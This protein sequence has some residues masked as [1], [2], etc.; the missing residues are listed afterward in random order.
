MTIN[1]CLGTF[2]HLFTLTYFL[3]NRRVID[4][5]NLFFFLVKV[6]IIII[7]KVIILR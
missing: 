6:D 7:F 4:G 3:P 2:I 5:I 1:H